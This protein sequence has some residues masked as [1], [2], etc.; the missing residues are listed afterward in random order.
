MSQYSTVCLA[1]LVGLLLW[2]EDESESEENNK[3]FFFALCT[4]LLCDFLHV[5]PSCDHMDQSDW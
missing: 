1:V 4:C 2:E 5:S 3:T